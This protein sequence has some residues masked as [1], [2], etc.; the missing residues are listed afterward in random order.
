MSRAS[1]SQTKAAEGRRRGRTDVGQLR[2]DKDGKRDDGKLPRAEGL[3]VQKVDLAL[4]R[5]LRLC[6]FLDELERFDAL[7]ALLILLLEHRIVCRT[8]GDGF[9]RDGRCRRLSRI[10]RLLV[11]LERE[12]ARRR[13]RVGRAS[14]DDG[15]LVERDD[16]AG[17]GQAQVDGVRH[18]YAGAVP[19]DRTREALLDEVLRRVRVDGRQDVVQENVLGRRVD[20][21]SETEARFLTTCDCDTCESA[22][23]SEPRTGE[24]AHPRAPFPSRQ[25]PFRRRARAA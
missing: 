14:R 1:Q 22:W 8:V 5:A 20:G 11:L 19:H 12:Q 13:E 25:P 15:S 18:E 16:E 7:A 21:A 4:D 10:V 2:A 24:K 6:L 9:D 3:E 23:L 17:V